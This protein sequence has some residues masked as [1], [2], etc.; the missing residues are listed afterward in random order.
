MVTFPLELPSQAHPTPSAPSTPPEKTVLLRRIARTAEIHP[1]RPWTLWRGASLRRSTSG[2]AL[3]DT[4]TAA[5]EG[6]GGGSPASFG[7][8]E[9]ARIQMCPTTW[10]RSWP[11][12]GQ[13]GPT[14]DPDSGLGVD[15]LASSYGEC[16][17]LLF[18][19]K[20]FLRR[21][22]AAAQVLARERAR[23]RSPEDA[24][25]TAHLGWYILGRGTP[26]GEAA[27][28]RQDEFRPVERTR[29]GARLEQKW[30]ESLGAKNAPP[31][32]GRGAPPDRARRS[33][34]AVADPRPSVWRVSTF[35]ALAESVDRRG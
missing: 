5:S 32:A 11:E 14:A 9:L 18:L 2:S 6:S 16:E 23:A 4:A 7:S 28:P 22:S 15:G 27:P 24:G 1:P 34:T 29:S 30:R 8:H 31:S 21:R 13:A 33:S 3:G 35:T 25:E 26:S 10:G 19:L 20:R 17:L 12:S